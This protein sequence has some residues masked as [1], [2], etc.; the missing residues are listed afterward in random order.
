MSTLDVT[1][2]TR[3]GADRRPTLARLTLV[4]LRKMVDTRAGFWLQIAIA[5]LTLLMV[6]LFCVIADADDRTLRGTLANAAV[7]PASILLPVL[8]VLLVTSEWSQRTAMVTFSLVPDRRRILS[9]KLLA[10]VLLALGAVAVCLPLS[11]LGMLVA[12]GSGD[13]WSLPAEAL[14]RAALSVVLGMLIGLG[15]GALLL[16]SAPAIVLYFVLP[17][18]SAAV[19]AIPHAEPVAVWLDP[20]GALSRLTADTMSGLDWAHLGTTLLLWLVVPLGVGAWRIGR[21][22]VRS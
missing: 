12:P 7:A 3:V 14:G 16:Y 5:G 1:L 10:G 9:A 4:E 11:A 19:G 6:A 18:V 21:G 8:G 2:P 13:V 22:E 20:T 15:F 17:F